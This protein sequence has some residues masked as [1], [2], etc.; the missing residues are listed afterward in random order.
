MKRVNTFVDYRTELVEGSSKKADAEI[1]QESKV[2]IDDIPLATKPP[3]IVDYKIHKE[4]KKTYYQI[5]RA[6]GSS[7]MY[8][9]FSHMLKSFDREDLETL[10]KLVKAKHGS[11]RARYSSYIGP[12]RLSKSDVEGTD[13][14]SSDESLKFMQFI[15]CSKLLNS[16]AIAYGSAMIN[17]H[18][19]LLRGF[20]SRKYND[21]EYYV[22]GLNHN[23]LSVGQFY[24]A[25]LE[26][27]FMKST[28]FVSDLQGKDLLSRTRGSDL[29]TITLQDLVSPT[30][31][32]LWHHRLS[33]LN[34][35]TINLLSKNDILNGLPKLMFVKEKLC[36]SCELG[37]AN[38]SSFKT[39]AVTRSKKW[40]DLLHMDLYGPMR[41]ESI[42][43]KKY[44]LVIVDDYLRYTWTY[45]LRSKDETPEVLKDFLNMI[46]CNL[47]AQS[48][49]Y[50]VYNKRIKLIVESI[51]INFNEIHQ[52]TPDDNTSGLAHQLQKTSVHNSTELK[53]HNH[54]NEPL[55]C[56]RNG[57]AYGAYQ[58]VFNKLELVDKLLKALVWYLYLGASRVKKLHQINTFYN[59]LTQS[60]QDSL[61]AAIGGNLLNH[62]PRDALTIIENKSKVRASRNKPIVSK[63]S[64]TTS[65]SS[66]SLDVTALTKNVG[67]RYTSLHRIK[68]EIGTR[69]EMRRVV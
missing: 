38:R 49:G 6:D 22:E 62:T 18:Q 8:L 2:A 41:V 66:P 26:V 63:V 4:G 68:H 65:S 57:W 5:I 37:K 53:I 23:L 46:Q 24:D 48:K 43:G 60:N 28:C 69:K 58:L 30:P 9:V 51:H 14:E 11:T 13:Y 29:Y 45:F 33:H 12:N 40:L 54:N 56:N 1:A 61:N 25:D 42:N 55:I 19:F 34:F 64:T 15:P 39:I 50:R 20:G 27:D 32:W 31:A 17:L 52:M 3:S 44:I 10:W 21:Q 16:E 67:S 47:Q 59:A 7:K 35:D 36:S